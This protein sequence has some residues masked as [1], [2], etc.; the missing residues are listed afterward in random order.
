[1]GGCLVSHRAAHRILAEDMTDEPPRRD[2][3]DATVIHC[4]LG[5]DWAAPKQ[6]G[7]DG[8]IFIGQRKAI[9]VT[10]DPDS[11]PGVEWIHAS[12]AHADPRRI[13]SYSDLKELHRAVFNSGHA[14]QCFVPNG[15][16]INITANVLHL[17]GRLDG[18]MALPAFGREGTI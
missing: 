8:W 7:D 16:H 14:Y 1:M 9:I 6:L 5:R 18:Q 12:I 17:W 3:I 15:E 13:P 4:R 10:Y 11:E 2:N